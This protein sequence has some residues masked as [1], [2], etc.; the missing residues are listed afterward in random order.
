MLKA[1]IHNDNIVNKVDFMKSPYI[2]I[3]TLIIGIYLFSSTNGTF[4][5]MGDILGHKEIITKF[6]IAEI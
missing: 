1:T 2:K 4:T 6:Y 5:K 3:Y